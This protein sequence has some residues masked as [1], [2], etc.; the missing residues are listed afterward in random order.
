MAVA[1]FTEALTRPAP[2][3]LP[4]SPWRALRKA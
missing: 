3:T 4:P 1:D 2:T